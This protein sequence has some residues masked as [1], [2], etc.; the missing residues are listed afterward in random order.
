MKISTS[1]VFLHLLHQLGGLAAFLAELLI[2]FAHH[3]Q[4]AHRGQDEFQDC[5]DAVKQ[6]SSWGVDLGILAKKS[7]LDVDG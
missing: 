5:E 3:K 7:S 1:D 6:E 4:A 2:D